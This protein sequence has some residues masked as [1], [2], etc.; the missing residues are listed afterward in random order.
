MLVVFAGLPASGKSY[1]ASRLG[2]VVSGVLLDKD[3]VRAALFPQEE[4]EYSSEQD[5]FCMQLIYQTATYILQKNPR[6]IVIIDGRP[7]AHAYQVEA[8][9]GRFRSAG[10]PI[11]LIECV[12]SEETAQ[13]RLEVDV[14]RGWHVAANRNIELY[15]RLKAEFEPIPQP[16]LVVN[17]DD[18]LERCISKCLNFIHGVE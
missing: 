7:F 11:R 4:I 1:L 5:D 3:R 18:D 17:T 2:A 9:L 14:A 10:I 8:L 6:K 16:K 15:Q 13:Q 12:C